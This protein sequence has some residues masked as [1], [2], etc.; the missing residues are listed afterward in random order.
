[1]KKVLVTGAGGA[2]AGGTAGVR[3][4]IRVG[5]AAGLV[6][7]AQNMVRSTVADAG[8]V[9]VAQHRG[10]LLYQDASGGA[11]TMTTATAANLDTEMPDLVTGSSILLMM[12]SN[13]AANTSTISGGNNVTLV[14]SGAVTQTGGI[15]ILIKTGAGTY[16]LV[17]VG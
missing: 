3:G 5:G 4:L 16:D 1:M 14:G 8:T 17:R 15:F 11:V 6:P 7:I 2:T 10:Q 12:A 9:T 13:H